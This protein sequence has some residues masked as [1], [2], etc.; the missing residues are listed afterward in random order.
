MHGE[1]CKYRAQFKEASKDVAKNAAALAKCA[2]EKDGL[3]K[4]CNEVTA[5]LKS[6]E[7]FKG[8]RIAAGPG[9]KVT[10]RA[11]EHE[12]EE[13]DRSDHRDDA[14]AAA[15]EAPIHMSMDGDARRQR[16]IHPE[17]RHLVPGP[18]GAHRGREQQASSRFHVHGHSAAKEHTLIP[19]NHCLVASGVGARVPTPRPEVLHM[20]NQLLVD[21]D[22]IQAED[23][24][25][26]MAIDIYLLP[27]PTQFPGAIQ[28]KVLF[29][30]ERA[31][32]TVLMRSMR[33][34][35]CNISLRAFVDRTQQSGHGE[36]R[37]QHGAPTAAEPRYQA[38]AAVQ[39]MARTLSSDS[40]I[41]V[42]PTQP[43]SA[44]EP[45]QSSA[46]PVKKEGAPL[47]FTTRH[48]AGSLQAPSSMLHPHA[49]A[50]PQQ[51][52]S[53]H[54]V[55]QQ[56]QPAVCNHGFAAYPQ[57]MQPMPPMVPMYHGGG[58][59]YGPYMQHPRPYYAPPMGYAPGAYVP[60]PEAYHAYHPHF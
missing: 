49:A 17:R 1:L 57:P 5:K 9:A 23:G 3:A 42:A 29:K 41:C 16:L 22:L 30:S 43:Q 54:P 44:P 32:D 24:G 31:A 48:A 51:A 18:Q 27:R 7:A 56:Q 50:A 28:W 2:K 21:S 37:H 55:T 59:A 33:Q 60:G 25:A 11:R 19:A 38:A 36:T 45:P 53:S 10:K 12:T 26:T 39:P 8:Q 4:K 35:Q 46:V 40:V 47:Q 15:N 13:R 34:T 52:P 6:A 14:A 20:V 58:P